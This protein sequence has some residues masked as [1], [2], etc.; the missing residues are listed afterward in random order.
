MGHIHSVYD[1][2]A[3]FK[4]DGV[5][6]TV[7]SE[8]GTKTMVVQYDHNSE[9]F[10][11]E[12]PRM[13]DGH[14]MSTCNVVQVH[15]INVDSR[16]KER[17]NCGVYEVDDLQISP[18]GDDVVICS[19]LISANATQFVGNLSFVV[20]FVCST[21]GNIDYAWNTAVHSNVY[22]TNG[23]YNGDA[24]IEIY[25]DILEQW[26]REIMSVIPSDEH[27]NSLIND[28]L[29]IATADDNGKFL[30]VVEGKWQAAE[31]SG[32]GASNEVD[33]IPLQELPATEYDSEFNCFATALIP[34][35]SAL[36]VGETYYVLWESEI[37]PCVGQDASATLPDTVAIGNGA[38]FGLTGNNEP[39]VIGV[40]NDAS[41]AVFLGLVDT[42]S[43]VYKVRVYRIPKPLPSTTTADNGKFLRVVD[44]EPV[45]VA[46]TNVSEEGA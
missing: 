33:V 44:G 4:I 37:Y 11:F 1:T 25:P 40:P 3:H 9:R 2:D 28:V 7:K 30:K 42:E 23:I 14:D 34:A 45:W 31:N 27:I 36:V 22:V 46:L 16:D 41:G 10:T 13:I 38:A 8:S 29:P 43:K 21:D 26:Y 15:Y 12:I 5:T 24:I 32:G 35:P 6:R 19:W 20:R 17:Q 39:F 18:D